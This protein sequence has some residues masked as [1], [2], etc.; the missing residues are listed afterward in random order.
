MDLDLFINSIQREKNYLHKEIFLAYDS[1][2]GICSKLYH[3]V[4]NVKKA[5]IMTKRVDNH[6]VK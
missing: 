3:I 2:Q 5:I 1:D 6:V 4:F